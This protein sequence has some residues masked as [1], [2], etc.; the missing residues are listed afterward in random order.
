M[1]A[2]VIA[3]IAIGAWT[4]RITRAPDEGAESGRA[5]PA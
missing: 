1:W 3:L 5:D 2:S 4:A